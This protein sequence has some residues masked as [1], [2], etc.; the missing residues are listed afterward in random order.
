MEVDK[1]IGKYDLNTESVGSIWSVFRVYL[2]I[3][4]DVLKMMAFPS[5]ISQRKFFYLISIEN[6]TNET[7]LEINIVVFNDFR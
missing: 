7:V 5:K 2:N 6:P 4:F 1:V 3:Y